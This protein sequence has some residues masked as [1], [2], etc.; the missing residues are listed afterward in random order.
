M[1]GNGP[2]LSKS[3]STSRAIFR[4]RDIYCVNT[5]AVSEYFT[6]IKPS[7]YVLAD[8]T[9]WLL[10]VSDIDRTCRLALFDRII[11][12]ATWPMV[13][14]APH[15]MR[16]GMEWR[17]FCRTAAIRC[18]NIS[19][20]Y[21]NRTP[22]NGFKCFRHL[23]YRASLGM[24]TAYNV[25]VAALFLAINAGYENIYFLG[26]DHSWHQNIVV[27]NDN[28]L[29]IKDSHFYDLKTNYKLF[30][31]GKAGELFKVH[32]VFLGWGRLFEVYILLNEYAQSRGVSI[33]N[34]SLES[35]ID[36]F[37]RISISDI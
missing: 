8:P 36:A 35:F 6:E 10:N 33:I 5:F 17:S 3:L 7:H 25:L 30:D 20:Q 12:S 28:L 27:K 19:V 13:V 32:E 24:P 34:V 15:E 22:V 4:D 11:D 21:F 2:S 18:P 23:I 29:Y 16:K 37:Q 31:K 9:F 14:L 26:A 1:L